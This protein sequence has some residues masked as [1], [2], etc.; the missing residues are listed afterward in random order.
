MYGMY[1][2]ACVPLLQVGFDDSGRISGILL[3][4]YNNSGYVDNDNTFGNFLYGFVDNGL[5][6][7]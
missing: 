7:C 1:V 3:N 4:M 5:W 2:C 6:S